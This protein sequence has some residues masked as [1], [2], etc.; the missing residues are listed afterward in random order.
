MLYLNRLR[1]SALCAV[2]VLAACGGA[3]SS[4][5]SSADAQLSN[6]SPTATEN[7]AQAVTDFDQ[8][9]EVSGNAGKI[10]FKSNVSTSWVDVHY[11]V[12][13]GGQQ[14][15][16]MSATNARF[17]QALRVATGDV[18]SYFFTYNNGAPAYDS[19]RF[20][21]T[22]GGS[23]PVNPAPPTGAVC[24]Y[25]YDV[26]KGASICADTDSN[27]IGAAWDNRVTS[28]KVTT[29]YTLELFSDIN[30]G[31]TSVKLTADNPNLMG[32]NDVASSYRITKVPAPIQTD[33]APA[34]YSLVWQDEFDKDGLPD[35]SKWVYDH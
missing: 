6:K 9:V 29:G 24:F 19:A 34:G 22:V 35:S 16:R 13:G 21:Y 3:G 4:L 17:E 18:L 20:S 33:N 26:Y 5:E 1:L 23:G 15:V 27:S 12:N 11:Q 8:G 25:E 7:Q 2:L 30:Y 31:G 32:F 10:W 28:V 14:N